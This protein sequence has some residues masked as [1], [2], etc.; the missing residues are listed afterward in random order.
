[1][2]PQQPPQGLNY[3]AIQAAFAAHMQGG[4]AMQQ[5][6]AQGQP[7][8]GGP[9]M[10]GQPAPQQMP[11]QQ[12]APQQQPMPQPTPAPQADM[13]QPQQQGPGY[14]MMVHAMSQA[15]NKEGED[16]GTMLIRALAD[17]A[18]KTIPD[19]SG[20]HKPTLPATGGGA[21]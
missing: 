1:M 20:I 17:L 19:V 21:Y 18:K 7:Q 13:P 6:P 10:Q 11:P 9:P 12:S 4:G 8:P 3:P 15:Q 2:Q 14:G 5:P 16:H